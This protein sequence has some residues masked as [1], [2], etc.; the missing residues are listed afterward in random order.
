[1]ELRTEDIIPNTPSLVVFSKRGYIKRMSADTFTA[2]RIRG[3]G[4]QAACTLPMLDPTRARHA[5]SPCLSLVQA[6]PGLA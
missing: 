5:P 2:Q 1:M 4:A 6:K 3:K